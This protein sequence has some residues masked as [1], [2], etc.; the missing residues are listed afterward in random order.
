MP[1]WQDSVSRSRELVAKALA[2]C[3]LD[4]AAAFASRDG[5]GPSLRRLLIDMIEEYARH[6]GHAG[7][8]TPRSRLTAAFNSLKP[9]LSRIR[10]ERPGWAGQGTGEW[11]GRPLGR[12]SSPDPSAR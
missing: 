8:G 12:T 1:L 5:R 9:G 7:D 11:L 10:G 4:H 2:D 6:V 3:G